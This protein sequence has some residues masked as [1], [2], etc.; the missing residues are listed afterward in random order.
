MLIFPHFFPADF[1]RK[2]KTKVNHGNH[3]SSKHAARDVVS[4][5]GCGEWTRLLVSSAAELLW[6]SII[7]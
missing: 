4:V 3:T 6:V 1:F 5:C 2:E 7:I